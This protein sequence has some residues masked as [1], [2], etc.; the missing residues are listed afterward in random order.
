MH[1]EDVREL[2]GNYIDQELTEAMRRR[3]EAHLEECAACAGD[4][5]TLN[6]TVARLHAEPKPE[7]PNAW[8][9]ERL[10]DRIARDHDTL[11]ATHTP[12]RPVPQLSLNI[13]E[14]EES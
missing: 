3:I 11:I 7:S 9:F 13:T 12:A 1:C 5:A 10:L 8:H 14:E 6:D 4:L 2:L